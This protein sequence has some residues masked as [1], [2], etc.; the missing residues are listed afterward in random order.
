MAL[1][2]LAE[3]H[4][5]LAPHDAQT[6]LD[7]GA[8][9]RLGDSLALLAALGRDVGVRSDDRQDRDFHLGL[10]ILP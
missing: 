8:R 5:K 1:E 6:L 9:L 4:Q 10:Q 3:I 2:C 7:L